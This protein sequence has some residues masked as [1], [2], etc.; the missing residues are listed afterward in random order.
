MRR[1][2]VLGAVALDQHSEGEALA[3]LDLHC[4]GRDGEDD[5]ASR[6][7]YLRDKD[8][9]RQKTAGYTSKARTKPLLLPFI[10][11]PLNEQFSLAFREYNT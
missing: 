5:G 4:V 8:K 6:L 11:H 9:S 3:L 1:A 7:G 10:F 2:Q